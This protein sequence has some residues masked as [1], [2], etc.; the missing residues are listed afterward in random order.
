MV[1]TAVPA[2]HGSDRTK[3]PARDARRRRRRSTWTA[4]AS[5]TS[6]SPT[7]P[8]RRPGARAP[9]GDAAAL[10]QQRPR[11]VPRHHGEG[12]GLDVPLYAMGVAAGGLR[13]RR[14]RGRV[15]DR[16]RAEP[17]PPQRRRRK[18][19]D[20]T[21][22]AGLGGRSA[23]STSAAWLDYDRDGLLDLFICNYVRWTPE[24]D[25]FC[26]ADGKAK[27]LLHAAGISRRDVVAVRNRGNGTFDDVTS[28]AGVLD[29]TSKALG[30]TVLD[31]DGDCGP[32]SSSPTT[33]SRTSCIATAGRHVRRGRPRGGARVQ[34][35]W[36]GPR[37]HGHRRRR[38]RQQ[39]RAVGGRHQFFRR[40]DRTL[41]PGATG[42]Y[43]IA[44]RASD[45]GRASRLTLGFGC[46]FFDADL[47]G[48]LDLLVVNGHIDERCRARR[49][50]RTMPSRR[51][52]FITAADGSSTSRRSSD[53]I[54]RRRRSA[55]ARRSPT[56]T[57][58]A[59][60]T[61]LVTTNGGPAK[62]Y[63]NDRGRGN[64]ACG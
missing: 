56:S 49:A 59:T 10:P 47:D 37:G 4:M 7:A 35:G 62:L 8:T 6:S 31:Y 15:R 39:R 22:R 21:E 2:L 45:L 43:A 51:T 46:F 54:S 29:P 27:V 16:G 14:P 19:G 26:S 18:F 55:E 58:T 20:A 11:T 63:R 52:C 25:V 60:S 38:P 53:R 44:R 41:Q 1:R 40:D 34:R 64:R 50:V 36:P 42:V 12:P 33:R 57:A 5:R 30:I 28:T 48:L 61:S 17:P 32:T 3:V 24:T 9:V 13:Q 23:F